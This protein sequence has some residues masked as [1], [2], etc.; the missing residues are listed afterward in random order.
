MPRVRITLGW[1]NRFAEVSTRM[2]IVHFYFHLIKSR[3]SNVKLIKAYSIILKRIDVS[4]A[5]F[6]KTREILRNELST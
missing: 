6:A 5:E 3:Y 2:I 1:A 4:V